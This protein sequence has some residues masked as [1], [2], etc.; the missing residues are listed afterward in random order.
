MTDSKQETTGLWLRWIVAS[1]IGGFVFA[2][3][4]RRWSVAAGGSVWDSM[5]PV[6]AEIVIGALA[7]GGI[8]AGIAVG[9]WLVVRRRVP[10]AG[11]L[12]AGMVGGGVAGGGAAFGVL[13]G[14]GGEGGGVPA[15]AAAVIVGLAAFVGVQWVLLR[16]RVPEAGRFVWMSVAAVVAAV[17]AT[18]VSGVALGEYSGGGVGGAVFG[19]AYA[20]VT[21]FVVIPHASRRSQ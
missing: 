4:A 18:G 14:M 20:A 1:A 21:G 12:A 10:W 11:W 2:I 6:V 7:L 17:V 3:A 5:G 19:A 16:G 13:Q 8:M 15:V 9:P